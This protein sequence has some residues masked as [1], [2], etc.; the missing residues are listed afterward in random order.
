MDPLILSFNDSLV[1]QSDLSLLDEGKWLNDRI[2]GFVFD[3]FENEVFKKECD[4]NL[5]AFINPSTVQYLKLCESLDEAATCF[6]EPLNL[7]E[8]KIVF[9][10]LNSNPSFDAGGSHWSF[11]VVDNRNSTIKHLDSIGSNFKEAEI[12]YKKYKKFLNLKGLES[13]KSFPEQTNS[14][15]CG[16]YSIGNRKKLTIFFN[17]V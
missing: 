6:L 10:P 3:Y 9:L 15:D 12:F 11:L 13:I 14:S 8:K 5:F 17:K 2:I 7:K 1:Y 16:A 4:Q